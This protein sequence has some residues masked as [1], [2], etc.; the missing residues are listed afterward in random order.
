MEY[1]DSNFAVPYSAQSMFSLFDGSRSVEDIL[2]FSAEEISK[3]QVLEYVQFLDEKALLHSPYFK[4]KAE[5]TEIV[6]E[7]S[8]IHPSC[9]AGLSYPDDPE[10][11]EHFLNEAFEKLPTTDPVDSAKA[12]YAPHIDYRVG[13]NSYVKAF[14]SIKNLKPKRVVI[15]ATSHYSGMYPDLYEERPFVISNKD[16][17]MVNGVVKTDQKAIQKIM[18]RVSDKELEYGITFQDRAHRIDHSIELHLILLNHLWNHDFEIVP[19]VVGSLDELF[20]KSDG[21]QGQQVEKFA[22]LLRDLVGDDKDTFFSVSGD[23]AHIGKK[24]GDDKPAKELFEEVRNFDES[25]LDFGEAGN[26]DKILDLMS[27]KYDPY[28]ICGYPPLYSF[29]KA[30]P[31]SSG[32]ILTYDVWDEEERDSGVSFGSILYT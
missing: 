10:E 21:F 17:E 5:Q 1:A 11:L 9:T 13:L 8:N 30:F 26:A 18:D 7:A 3:E 12:L 19:I 22:S 23:L 2:A 25:F 20:Y 29:L 32:E 6:Y 16:F 27:K 28:R 14:S 31:E 15:L 24:F 4:E